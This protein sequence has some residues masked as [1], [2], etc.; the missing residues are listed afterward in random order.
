MGDGD[1]DS[2]REKSSKSLFFKREATRARAR[3]LFDLP[4][5]PS[6]LHAPTH[7]Q[8]AATLPTKTMRLL[9]LTVLALASASASTAA[10][11]A[12]SLA[13]V[14]AVAAA[15][16]SAPAADAAL[17]P[18]QEKKDPKPQLWRVNNLG[19]AVHGG[20]AP[21]FSAVSDPAAFGAA[22]SATPSFLFVHG[23]SFKG[24]PGDA[25]TDLVA[26]W[27]TATGA[28]K[29]DGSGG[30]TDTTCKAYMLVR[31]WGGN[32]GKKRKQ[33][34]LRGGGSQG[35]AEARDSLGGQGG[36]KRWSGVV[37]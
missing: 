13:E 31:K 9:A 5:S 10:A 22:A 4:H 37:R 30:C 20:A 8:P 17:L 16:A 6:P 32:K 12:R 25:F 24:T 23:M 1:G 21:S 15:P 28:F 19:A 14:G 18:L 35:D 29:P 36:T 33:G 27:E 11:A 3:A 34:G 7:A 2:R 26:H